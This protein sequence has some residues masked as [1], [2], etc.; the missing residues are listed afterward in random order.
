MSPY[1]GNSNKKSLIEN[2][3]KI[4]EE[5]ITQDYINKCCTKGFVDRLRTCIHRDGGYTEK[6][7]KRISEEQNSQYHFSMMTFLYNFHFPI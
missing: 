5:N 3:T 1:G 6:D 2:L 4:W 7:R